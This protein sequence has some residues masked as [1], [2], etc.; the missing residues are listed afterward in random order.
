MIEFDTFAIEQFWYNENS[1]D[2]YLVDNFNCGDIS[3]GYTKMEN[4]NERSNGN[5]RGDGWSFFIFDDFYKYV[6]GRGQLD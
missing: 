3:K 2:G 1:V 5:G 6:E 4:G